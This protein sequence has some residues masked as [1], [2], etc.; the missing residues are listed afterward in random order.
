MPKQILNEKLCR[1]CDT[2]KPLDQFYNCK[3]N[4]KFGVTSQC[5]LC[6]DQRNKKN[7]KAW[8]NRN[9]DM[10]KQKN[11]EYYLKKK[12]EREQESDEESNESDDE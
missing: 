10:I 12:A 3:G 8:R 7:T 1:K 5:K 11:R 4:N 2:V 6:V 9:P